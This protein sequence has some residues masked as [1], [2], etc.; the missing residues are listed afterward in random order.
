[1]FTPLVWGSGSNSMAAI[2]R[3]LAIPNWTRFP[4]LPALL[5]E[6]VKE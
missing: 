3:F 6:K 5:I 4:R 1:M 2:H